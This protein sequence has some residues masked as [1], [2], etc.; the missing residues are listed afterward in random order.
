MLSDC[1]ILYFCHIVWSSASGKAVWRRTT[2]ALAGTTP[3]LAG[4]FVATNVKANASGNP[5]FGA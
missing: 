3:A 5:S 4:P 2:T 1:P